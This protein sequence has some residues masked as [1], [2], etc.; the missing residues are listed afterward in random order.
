[1]TSV[2]DLLS[3]VTSRHVGEWADMVGG[4][5]GEL[6]V[7]IGVN[8]AGVLRIMAVNETA[9]NEILARASGLISVW[10]SAAAQREEREA[11]ALQCWV[12]EGLV[13]QGRSRCTTPS[14]AKRLEVPPGLRVDAQALTGGVQDA[15]VREALVDLRA[16]AM[17]R[18]IDTDASE[19]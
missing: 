10:N 17:A 16:R 2:S 12:R 11:T 8:D 4:L 18:R 1:M 7:P 15:S 14:P 9:K 5:L 3:S 19:E 6:S 13:A